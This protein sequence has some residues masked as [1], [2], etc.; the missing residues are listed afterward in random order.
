MEDNEFCHVLLANEVDELMDIDALCKLKDST[1][2]DENKEETVVEEAEPKWPI[3]FEML[4]ESATKLKALSVQIG[5][6]GEDYKSAAIDARDAS[7]KIRS[8]FR[9]ANSKKQAEKQQGSRQSQINS[10]FNNE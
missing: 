3:N 8:T 1:E 10:F 5:E 7:D 2:D 4:D 9:K 6:L